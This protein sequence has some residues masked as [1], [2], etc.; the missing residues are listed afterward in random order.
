MIRAGL[1]AAAAFTIATSA[2]AAGRLH[3]QVDFDPPRSMRLHAIGADL[4]VNDVATRIWQFRSTEGGEGLAAYFTQQW[5]GRVA[6]HRFGDWDV[7][8]HREGDWLLTVQTGPEDAAG[9]SRGFVAIAERFSPPR[10]S[11]RDAIASIPGA[12]IVQGIDSNDAGRLSRTWLMVSDRPPTSAL[13][14]L[15]ANLRME[16]FEPIGPKALSRSDHGGAMRL[17]RGAEQVNVAVA[18]RDGRTWI[19][20]VRVQP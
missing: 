13:D 2:S 3:P 18:E 19:A 10:V 11:H 9:I 17:N 20:I 16:G 1:A 14:H 5:N 7:L 6:R 15:R 8:S 4:R 12:R